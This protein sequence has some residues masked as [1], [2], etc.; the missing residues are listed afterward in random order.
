MANS[1]PVDGFGLQARS[2][3]TKRRAKG[4]DVQAFEK[5][6]GVEV[7]KAGVPTSNG[8][9]S[10]KPKNTTRRPH[11]VVIWEAPDS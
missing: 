2:R 5:L 3:L 11:E 7:D 6:I 4:E 1:K 10:P 8:K 9:P